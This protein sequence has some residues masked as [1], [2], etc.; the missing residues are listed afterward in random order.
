MYG[1]QLLGL[2]SPILHSHRCRNGSKLQPP[3][4]FAENVSLHRDPDHL[5]LRSSVLRTEHLIFQPPQP[6]RA[7]EIH[8]T[9]PAIRQHRRLQLPA[10]RTLRPLSQLDQDFTLGTTCDSLGA[11]SC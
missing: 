1:G 10:G 4:P 5:E 3:V 2:P 6:A 8:S 9:D 7:R 11:T